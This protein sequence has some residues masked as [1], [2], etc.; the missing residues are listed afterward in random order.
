MLLLL[1]LLEG[2][3]DGLSRR[4]LQSILRPN[5]RPLRGAERVSKPQVALVASPP[6]LPLLLLP[7][8]GQGGCIPD[9]P[10]K[11]LV[12]LTRGRQTPLPLV[13]PARGGQ[14]H[15]TPPTPTSCQRCYCHHYDGKAW[16]YRDKPGAVGLTRFGVVFLRS[17]F[18]LCCCCCCELTT[19]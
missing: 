17:S 9:R 19:T 8:P 11:W 2:R 15:P 3:G 10:H 7:L 6:P 1:L 13:R 12:D 18:C 14:P 16:G 4:K 5:P